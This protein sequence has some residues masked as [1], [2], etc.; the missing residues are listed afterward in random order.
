M[1]NVRK[2]GMAELSRIEG[3][4]LPSF[5]TRGDIASEEHAMTIVQEIS[6]A[7]LSRIEGGVFIPHP[8]IVPPIPD[9]GYPSPYPGPLF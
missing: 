8:P 1:T 2:I 4:T 6:M 3:G 5:P 7:E 9:G